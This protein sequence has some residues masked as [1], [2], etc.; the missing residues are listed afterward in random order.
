MSVHRNNVSMAK[1][2][3]TE[4]DAP[5]H[6]RQP[7]PRIWVRVSLPKHRPPL[8]GN[9]P[10]HSLLLNLHPCAVSNAT[11]RIPDGCQR[12]S[13]RFCALFGS[14]FVVIVQEDVSGDE[15]RKESGVLA[16]R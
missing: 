13:T 12:T 8:L 4:T 7:S 3:K 11:C 6:V 1:R 15:V 9:A 14:N 5:E 16:G 2:A 10:S